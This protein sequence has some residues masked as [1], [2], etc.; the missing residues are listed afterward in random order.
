MPLDDLRDNDGI[1]SDHQRLLRGDGLSG[2]GAL[3]PLV[4]LWGRGGVISLC[5][6]IIVLVGLGVLV[7]GLNPFAG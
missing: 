5:V 6:I 1:D 3:N 2:L 4:A 7:F